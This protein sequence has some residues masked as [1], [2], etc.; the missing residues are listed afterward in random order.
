MLDTEMLM[1]KPVPN[2]KSNL[3]LQANRRWA[4]EK[5]E[6][7]SWIHVPPPGDTDF[8]VSKCFQPHS[9]NILPQIRFYTD[10]KCIASESCQY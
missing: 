3:I 9:S 4:L 7:K 10:Y 5:K 8:H 2:L 1:S 6:N